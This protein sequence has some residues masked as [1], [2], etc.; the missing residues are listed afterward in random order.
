MAVT[1][2]RFYSTS[3]EGKV[4]SFLKGFL[5]GSSAQEG[6]IIYFTI[7]EVKRAETI[8]RIRATNEEV[9]KHLERLALTMFNKEEGWAALDISD[10]QIKTQVLVSCQEHLNRHVS[11]RSLGGISTLGDVERL[12]LT[13]E[14]KGRVGELFPD[15]RHRLGDLPPNLSVNLPTR[16]MNGKKWERKPFQN[17][18]NPMHKTYPNKKER[19]FNFDKRN[20]KNHKF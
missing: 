18:D 4:S 19:Q 13:E 1:L 7:E 20:H 3:S 10:V 16:K 5:F 14:L 12:F 15:L 11:N 8:T 6:Y 17:Y 2:R 9:T